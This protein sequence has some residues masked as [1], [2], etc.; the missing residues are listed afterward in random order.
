MSLQNL[1]ARCACDE[2]NF[3]LQHALDCPLGGLRTIQHNETR[4]TIAKLMRDA[5]LACVESEPKLLPLTGESFE[6]KTTN[7]DD[8]ARADIKC[9]GLWRH[10]RQAYFDV[11]VVSP[12]ARSYAKYN[13]DQL[14]RRAEKTKINEYGTR[15]KEV[16]RAD[17][18]PLVF[19]CAGGVG[20]KSH[21]LFK[22]LAE[23]IS[24]RHGIPL[25]QV[26]GLIRVKI[27]FALLRTTILCVRATRRKK[28]IGDSNLEQTINALRF[29]Y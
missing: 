9:T 7:K 23:L 2:A 11:K 8:E 28:F 14:Y 29:D 3:S 6:L 10:M 24:E 20:P 1:P 22:R 12:Y 26:S 19:T 21:N 25:S 15:I 17:F 18:M 4:D 16:D 13:P 5:G 27:S